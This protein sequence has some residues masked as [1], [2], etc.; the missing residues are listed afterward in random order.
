MVLGKL[1]IPMSFQKNETRPLY[2]SSVTKI[3]SKYI[4]DLHVN[5]KTMKL[6]E[7][8]TGKTLQDNAIIEDF[9]EQDTASTGK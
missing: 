5:H 6:W 9:F 8:N 4:K 1:G 7:E 2:L 3:N